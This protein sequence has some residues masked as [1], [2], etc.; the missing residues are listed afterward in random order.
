LPILQK[1]FRYLLRRR[2]RDRDDLFAESAA[3]AWKAWVGLVAKGRDPVAVGVTGIAA[4]AVRHTLKGRQIGRGRN[5]GGRSKMSVERRRARQLGGYKIVSYDHGETVRNDFGPGTWQ[6]WVASDHRTSPAAAA[7]FSI[8]Y[9][10]WLASLPE[11][12]RLA[13]ELLAEGHGTLEVSRR[14]GVSPPAITQARAW[15]ERSWSAFQ[16]EA[17]ATAN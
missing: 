4:F 13:A 7:A 11:R 14:I 5:G 6:R 3:C 9:S 10:T 16:Q 17:T 12:R 2:R 1:N 15:L 8:D